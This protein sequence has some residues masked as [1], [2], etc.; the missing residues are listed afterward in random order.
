MLLRA[1]TP[2]LCLGVTLKNNLNYLLILK[3]ITIHCNTYYSETF[4]MKLH[5]CLK[6]YSTDST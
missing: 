1:E 2:C 3:T 4:A 6:L 5:V